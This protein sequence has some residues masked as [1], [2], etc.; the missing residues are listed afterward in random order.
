MVVTKSNLRLTCALVM[1]LTMIGVCSAENGSPEATRADGKPGIVSFVKVLTD[2]VED[3]SNMEAWKKSFIK[4]GM[5][6]AEKALA[7]WT[8]NVKFRQQDSP[9]H[10]YLQSDKTVMDA[11]KTYNVY[12]YG[13]CNGASAGILAL[14]RYVGLN[15][16][17]RGIIQHSVPEVE[18]DGAWHLMDASL[19][20]YFPKPDGKLASVEEIC[21]SVMDW[22]AKNPGYEGDDKKLSAFMRSGEWKKNGPQLIANCPFLDSKGWYPALTHGWYAPMGE[23]ADKSKTHFYEY[24]Y[25]QGYQVNIQLREGERITRNWSNKGLHVNMREGGSPHSLKSQVGKGDLS[26]APK[27]GDIAVG[28]IGNG[29][30]EYDV[31]LANGAFRGGALTVENLASKSEDNADP[32]VHVKDAA[33]PG[34]LIIRM[35]S[36]YVY[37]GGEAIAKAVV[38]QGGEIAVAFSENNGLTWKELTKITATGESKIDLKDVIFRRYDYRLKLTMKGQGTGLDALKLTHDIQHSQRALPGFT[39]GKNTVSFSAGPAEGTITIEGMTDPKYMGKNI[40]FTEYQPE[41]NGVVAKAEAPL[42]IPSGKGE[43]TFPISTPGEMTRLRFGGH[44]RAR[45]KED[46]WGLQVSFDDGKTFKTV[47]RMAGPVAGHTQWVTFSDIPAGTKSAK[48][49]YAGHQKGTTC[50]FSFRIDADYKEPTGGLRP[51]KVTYNWEEGG[52]PQQKV[53]TGKSAAETFSI[54]CAEK[55]TMKSIVLELAD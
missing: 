36:S 23:Y 5:T 35:P 40:Y 17:G 42:M 12:G 25:S 33:N 30:H 34:V 24:G 28:R 37:L 16:R 8:T 18:Y 27:Y 4:D 49:R 51:V 7:V 53:L 38:A 50:L 55:P 1:T 44:Y 6:D 2:K 31:P 39:Q 22:Y 32:A 47:D 52:K 14:S 15:A 54:D 45:G 9:P 11:I 3:V 43:L 46:G 19:I 26:Y 10:E 41:A 20:T 21:D 29:T 48:V 13:M